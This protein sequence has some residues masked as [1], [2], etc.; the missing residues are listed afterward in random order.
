M[1]TELIVTTEETHSPDAKTVETTIPVVALA[2]PKI[3][4]FVGD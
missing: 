1:D 4:P 3:P 2:G